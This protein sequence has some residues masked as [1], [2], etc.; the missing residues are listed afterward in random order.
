MCNNKYVVAYGHQ[1][2][3]CNKEYTGHDD[4]MNYQI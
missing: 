4:D 3:Q 2:R 1:Y